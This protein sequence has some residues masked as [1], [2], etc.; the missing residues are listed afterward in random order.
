MNKITRTLLKIEDSARRVFERAPFF[1]ASLA[2][3][4]V[5]IFWRGIWEW[6]DQVGVSPL[7][8]V[9]LGVL[10]LGGV[11]VFVQTFIGNTI[12]IREVKHDEK[13]GKRVFAKVE[14][15]VA[16]ESATINE[17]SNKL[18]ILIEKLDKK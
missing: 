17:I 3:V 10:I 13:T 16:S 5:I 6:L 4:G 12:I 15:E 11:G 8:S 7:Y 14:G 9:I 18:D 1:Q 2:G